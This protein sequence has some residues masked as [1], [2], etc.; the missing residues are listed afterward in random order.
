M[1]F[2]SLSDC[3]MH[4]RLATNTRMSFFRFISHRCI[5]CFEIIRIQLNQPNLF[6]ILQAVNYQ[7]LNWNG[8]DRVL[9]QIISEPLTRQLFMAFESRSRTKTSSLLTGFLAS[10][11]VTDGHIFN[12]CLD[13]NNY[14]NP[15]GCWEL[16]SGSINLVSNLALTPCISWIFAIASIYFR[17]K[18]LTQDRSSKQTR[19][20]HALTC[21]CRARVCVRQQS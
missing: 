7:K 13:N 15:I 18:H 2:N 8:R 12:W 21:A 1:S 16:Q 3:V 4:V 17:R 19:S 9:I 10:T 20:K 11:S 5:G 6:Q 14:C